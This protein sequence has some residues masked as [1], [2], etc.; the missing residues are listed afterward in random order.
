MSIVLGDIGGTS[1]R[2]QMVRPSSA[3]TAASS[4]GFDTL[5]TRTYPSASGSSFEALL[6]RFLAE[7]DAA[8]PPAI[9]SLAVCGPVSADGVAVL[10]A[11]AFGEDGWTV[12]AA[13]LATSLPAHP[14]RGAPTVLLL[15]DFHAVGLA[16]D[17]VAPN[18]LWTLSESELG[19]DVA[20]RAAR[21]KACVFACPCC[22]YL[23]LASRCS[24]QCC[25]VCG[26]EDDGQGDADAEV[27]R[28]GPNG[29]LS[30]AQARASFRAIGACDTD[31]L[32]RC[33][34]PAPAEIPPRGARD[35]VVAIL[36][37]GSGLGECF[38]VPTTAAR[39]AASASPA[40]RAP[41]PRRVFPCEGSMSDFVPRNALELALRDWI[42][43]RDGSVGDVV[44]VEK[45][46]SGA[47]IA[48]IY[49]FLR[50]RDGARVVNAEL[51]A[52]IC[53]AAATPGGA[54]AALIGAHCGPCALADSSSCDPRGD[55]DPNV[56]PLCARAVELFLDL[57]GAEAANLACRYKATGGVY[58]AGGGI[59][60]KLLKQIRDGGR[61]AASYRGRGRVWPVYSDCPLFVV[62]TPGDALGLRGAWAW[63]QQAVAPSM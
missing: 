6:V 62:G 24:Y 46:V 9:Y 50:E 29:S 43:R 26:W 13:A 34:A 5:C 28:G 44:E 58:I 10:L 52:A 40:P 63:A 54:P 21:A 4:A 33:R 2:L 45:V 27:V 8:K 12:S 42:A 53:A 18:E 56:D 37:P 16:L 39:G 48:S 11:P 17:S 14:V 22:K 25:A 38:A 20:A 23:T 41:A 7:A 36:G 55:L 19:S 60:R 31:S 30:L 47:G 59:A 57:L 61:V 51:D 15:N 49:A 1:C 3:A 32:V 35:G